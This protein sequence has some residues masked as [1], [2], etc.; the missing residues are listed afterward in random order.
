MYD[1][2]VMC[3]ATGDTVLVFHAVVFK[4]SFYLLK[5]STFSLKHYIMLK[6]LYTAVTQA[7]QATRQNMESIAIAM[8]GKFIEIQARQQGQRTQQ[9]EA[10]AEEN[11]N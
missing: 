9:M 11:E 8:R 10:I 4:R 1:L 2:G 6:Y 5:L 3:A 7:I